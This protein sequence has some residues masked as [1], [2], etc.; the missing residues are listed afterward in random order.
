MS[1]I[2]KY[3][4]AFGISPVPMLL[5]AQDG[6]ILLANAD[7][8]AL[9][10]YDLDELT[11]MD[12]EVLMPVRHRNHQAALHSAYVQAF[13]Q[14]HPGTSRDLHGVTKTGALIPLELNLEYISE[15][16][17]TMM[18]VVAIDL[19]H[20][21]F[22][23]ELLHS[24]MDAAASAMIMVN[25]RGEIVFVNRSATSLFGYEEN[26]MLGQRVEML[27]P[28]EFQRVHQ[29]YSGN[30][31]DNRTARAM[32]LGRDLYACR[33]DGSRFPVEIVLT[34]VDAPTGKM[35]MST[36]VDLTER[37]AA[38]KAVAQKNAELAALN[39]E[40]SHYA[41]SASHDL[42]A[43]LLS[44]TGLLSL[45]IE[46]M[47]EGQID[48]LRENLT[49]AIEISRRSAHKVEGVLQIAR[50]GR[51]GMP[52]TPVLLEPTIQEIWLDLTGGN[53]RARLALDLRHRDPVVTELPT[54]KVII[55][56]M[57]SNALRYVDTA[58]CEHL[59][60]I[61][62]TTEGGHVRITISDNGIG[63]PARNVQQVFQMFK[64]LDERSGDGLGL[65]L[66]QK[67]IERLGGRI[68][69]ESTE[70]EGTRFTFTLPSEENGHV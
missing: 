8:E 48:E 44:I 29:I 40:L 58:K 1:L 35:V 38:A 39:I 59:I 22:H 2:E 15:G 70:G 63:I 3:R 61:T 54:L 37:F 28:K 11:G 69:V 25:E 12:V 33:Q 20:R 43:P 53:S 10:E 52:K 50:V 47:E 49:R 30:F 17:E 42:K 26:D 57:L 65:S 4:L 55:E 36:I 41:Y 16:S 23:E 13:T 18:L 6:K 31:M 62:S 21:K 45:S 9:F 51:D 56:N 34:P 46:A 60:G 68:A 66:V 5:V 19:R 7:F 67:Q 24:A 14:R 64:R 27:V 32:G